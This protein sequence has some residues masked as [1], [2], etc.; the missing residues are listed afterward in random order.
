MRIPFTR[1]GICGVKPRVPLKRID[2]PGVNF[3]VLLA[4]GVNFRIPL[5]RIDISGVNVRV[6]QTRLDIRGVSFKGALY[7]FVLLA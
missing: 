3:R 4:I 7:E 2:T 5:T 6:L 1:I